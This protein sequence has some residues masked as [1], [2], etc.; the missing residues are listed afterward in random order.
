MNRNTSKIMSGNN[1]H[2]IKNSSILTK[3][4]GIFLFFVLLL[5]S[6][7]ISGVIPHIAF[8]GL[9]LLCVAYLLLVGGIK[10]EDLRFIYPPLLMLVVVLISHIKGVINELEISANDFSD[11][12]KF[13]MPY[14]IFLGILAV[15]RAGQE[16]FI[17]KIVWFAGFFYACMFFIFLFDGGEFIYRL[18]L[19]RGDIDKYRYGGI[20][21]NPNAYAA[22]AIGLFFLLLSNGLNSGIF[23]KCIILLMA[24]SLVFSQSR[25]NIIAFAIINFIIFIISDVKFW[26]K[27]VLVLLIISV[28]FYVFEKFD[29]YWLTTPGRFDFAN[30]RSFSVRFER[31]GEEFDKY[32][33]LIGLFG[34]GPGKNFLDRLDTVS[35][36]M[37]FIRYGLLGLLIFLILHLHQVFYFSKKYL[38]RN[39]NFINLIALLFP[40]YVLISNISNEKWIDLKF[41]TVW[42][43]F[44]AYAKYKNDYS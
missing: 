11:Y 29:L 14:T 6:A 4:T 19:G 26:K 35:Y 40:I 28:L 20:D 13:L 36:I 17:F 7:E 1:N 3:I 25:T 41:L 18:G 43:I 15:F 2:F 16:K 23:K 39:R 10:R 37:Y 32:S 38:S 22:I 44:F 12:L 30:D 34:V 24:L 27:I 8:F 9:S 21:E 33:N 5:P 42:M 31:A